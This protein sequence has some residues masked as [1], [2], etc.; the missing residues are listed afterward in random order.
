MLDDFIFYSSGAK[1]LWDK[2]TTVNP[3]LDGVM[4]W[5][6]PWLDSSNFIYLHHKQ[7]SLVLQ[8]NNN[9]QE[10]RR[11][12][13]EQGKQWCHYSQMTFSFW[14]PQKFT[15]PWFKSYEILRLGKTTSTNL[16]KCG[17]SQIHESKVQVTLKRF[18]P[19]HTGANYY[20]KL[21]MHPND[22]F[23]CTLKKWYYYLRY[24]QNLYIVLKKD[25]VIS[26]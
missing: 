16:I 9:N 12:K 5:C 8:E 2:W 1:N 11:K 24:F 26:M 7:V 19:K 3:H 17:F 4:L 13:L 21:I 18:S 6:L 25:V 23:L 20:P 14:F 22:M 10:S 15:W